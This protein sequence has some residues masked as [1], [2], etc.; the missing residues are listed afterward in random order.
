MSNLEKLIND[1]KEEFISKFTV[2]ND[3]YRYA[4]L[5]GKEEY[6]TPDMIAN[7]WEK[8]LTQAYNQVKEDRNEAWKDIETNNRY[9]IICSK[10]I[11]K[12]VNKNLL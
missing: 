7:W 3:K 2:W 1:A 9:C 5:E 10:K 12:E 8:K 6:P 11:K 4:T